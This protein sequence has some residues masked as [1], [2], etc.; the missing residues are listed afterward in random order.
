M[1]STA[2]V[3]RNARVAADASAHPVEAEPRIDCVTEL[4]SATISDW[5]TLVADQP[6]LQSGFFLPEFSQAVSRVRKGV[7]YV[8]LRDGQRIVALFP[9]QRIGRHVANP[10]GGMMS[11]FHGLITRPGRQVD[12]RQ[13]MQAAG[14]RRFDFHA[15]QEDGISAE[16]RQIQR[17]FRTLNCPLV[18]LREGTGAYREWVNRHSSTVRRQPQK[19]RAMIRQLGPLRF[20]F[21][22][23][24]P[25]TLEQLI[26][27]KRDRYQ[28]TRTFDL[29]GLDWTSNLLR[30]LFDVR[31]ES[32][33]GLLSALWAGDHLVAAHFGFVSH[34][35]LH[36]WFPAY[37]YRH[38][39]YSPGTQL[40]IEIT[41]AA[42]DSGI[43]RIDLGYGESD[44]KHRFANDRTTVQYGCYAWNAA[45]RRLMHGRYEVRQAMKRL[46]G[47]EALKKLVRPVWPNLGKGRFR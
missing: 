2:F 45:T 44:L 21:D 42:A 11:D 16:S 29:L 32:F 22:C 20:E 12:F 27:M 6:V 4:D 37:Q 23:R 46:P 35:I 14:I 39:R 28:R 3:K 30:D 33:R 26:T 8:V 47:K 40:M 18:D 31:G 25:S 7:E 41:S 9:F 34:G 17:V 10:V 43:R 1:P 13:L 38:R 36:Y 24:A 19:T 15:W 5:Q